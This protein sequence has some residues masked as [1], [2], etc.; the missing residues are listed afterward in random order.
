MILTPETMPKRHRESNFREISGE[1]G[2]IVIPGEAEI[3][4]ANPVGIRTW[5][6]LD[7]THTVRQIVGT[8]VQEFE[9][10]E[11]QALRDVMEFLGDLEQ[12]G[13]LDEGEIH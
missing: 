8:I 6:L 4:V 10:D 12:R 2:L 11:D 1:G 5:A 13:L 9:V 3:H 7:G